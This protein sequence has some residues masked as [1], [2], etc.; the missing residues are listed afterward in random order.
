MIRDETIEAGR[1]PGGFRI[2]RKEARRLSRERI[3]AETG[4][5]VAEKELDRLIDQVI[6]TNEARTA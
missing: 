1:I 3:E 4:R 5:K 2:S 6:E